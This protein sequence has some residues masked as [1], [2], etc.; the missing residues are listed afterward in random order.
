MKYLLI[1]EVTNYFLLG[2]DRRFSYCRSVQMEYTVAHFLDPQAKEAITERL[3]CFDFAKNTLL[4]TLKELADRDSTLQPTPPETQ[5]Q[6]IADF[7]G[8]NSL[9]ATLLDNH[10]MQ[11]YGATYTNTGGNS[12]AN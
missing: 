6:N 7:L 1:Q 2:I 8:A 5:S 3:E 4:N 11:R 9:M 10:H 12:A